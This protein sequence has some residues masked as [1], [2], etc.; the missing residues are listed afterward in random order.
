MS[1]VQA[2]TPLW[3]YASGSDSARKKTLRLLWPYPSLGV[4]IPF[5]AFLIVV[6]LQICIFVTRTK[7]RPNNLH[8]EHHNERFTITLFHCNKFELTYKILNASILY[9]KFKYFSWLA[10]NQIE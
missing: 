5:H 3:Y 1:A 10:Q 9:C 2:V 6:A 4:L 8:G 7:I